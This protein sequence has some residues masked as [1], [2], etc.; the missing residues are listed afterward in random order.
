MLEHKTQAEDGTIRHALQRPNGTSLDGVHRAFGPQVSQAR[1]IRDEHPCKLGG[2]EW[3]R[4][5]IVLTADA[6]MLI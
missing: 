6:M 2:R 4:I 1:A 3:S 5:I